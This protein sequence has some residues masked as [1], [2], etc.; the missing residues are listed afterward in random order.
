MWVVICRL[1][2]IQD[3]EDKIIPVTNLRQGDAVR[4][5]LAFQTAKGVA[6]TAWVDAN[7][8]RADEAPA[9]DPGIEVISQ[10]GTT[11]GPYEQDEGAAIVATTPTVEAVIKPSTISLQVLLE[12]LLGVPAVVTAS[13]GPGTNLND[14][15][16]FAFGI[17]KRITYIWDDTFETIRAVDVWI[18]TMEFRSVANEN[19][20]V[21]INGTGESITRETPAILVAQKL[22]V[23]DTYS[24]KDSILIDDDGVAVNLLAI[25]MTLNIDHGR[26]TV[27]GNT[28]APNFVG[29]DGRIIVT[30]SITTRLTDETAAFFSRT[31]ALT[32]TKLTMRWV[33]QSGFILEI[34]LRNVTL[35]APYPRVNADGTLD[36]YT[37]DFT[38]RQT[39]DGGVT[40]GEFPF[41]VRVED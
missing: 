30:G 9:P 10:T 11:G 25:D 19:L 1:V 21:A 40:T 17:P 28:V 32:R 24:H 4:I 2:I 27:R 31:L 13:G 8:I 35:N 5:A 26:I 23:F 15:E 29:K 22:S 12:S 34:E 18:H 14:F 33:Q 36:N 39:G 6:F 20:V 7:M 41:R 37:F 3:G 38:A 16:G